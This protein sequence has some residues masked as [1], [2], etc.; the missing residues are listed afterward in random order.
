MTA[1]V[2]VGAGLAAVRTAEALRRGGDTGAITL[3]GAEPHPPYDR[4]PLSK[5]LLRGELAGPAEVALKPAEFYR[6]NDITLRL[7]AAATR[8]DP[9]A[10]TV[11]LA[12]GA[13]IGY[14]RLVIATGVTPRWLPGCPPLAGVHLLRSVD[15]AVALRA[16]VSAARRAVVV[17]AG[18]IGCEVTAAL[19]AADVAVTLV[20]PAPAPLA[21]VVG[22]TVG[23]LIARLHRDEGVSVRTGVGVGEVTG[24][25]H[26][27]SVT[28][29][30]GTTVPADLVVVGIGS[31]PVTDWLAGSGVRI[32][33]G[34]VCDP[35]GR[36]SVPDVWALGDVAA[37]AYGRTH[38]RIEH[39]SNVADQART[40]AAVMAGGDPPARATVPY[41]WSDQ[42][43]LKLQC[44]GDPDPGDA[45]HI[46]E[47]RGREFLA[48]YERDGMLTAVV[49]AGMATQIRS[50][51]KQLTAPTPIAEALGAVTAV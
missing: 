28:L 11:V 4:P 49:A 19:R 39:W 12:D 25:G 48:Y 14:D 22:P 24:A 17:G 47:D 29:D 2:I 46:A 8:L 6:D 9:D 50:A 3:V 33:N 45:V 32:D 37:W 51:R 16:G 18:F 1:T 36:T 5:Q 7:G 35:V 31:R 23:A 13:R 34:V 15:Q 40:V 30:D 43:E 20:D 38:R 26:V 44:L 41:V 42:Y 21:S 27:E 10:H